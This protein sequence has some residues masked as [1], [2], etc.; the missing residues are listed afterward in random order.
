MLFDFKAYIE[1][2]RENPEKK[3]VVEKYEKIIWTIDWDTKDQIWYKEYVNKFKTIKYLVPEELKE[4][5]DWDLLMQLVASSLSSD[6]FLSQEEWKEI[7]EFTI[8]VQSGDQVVVKKV[9]ELWGFQ[10]S[11]LYEIYIEEQMN[12]QILMM[13]DEKEKNAIESQREAKEHRWTIVLENLEKEKL[14]KIEK[15]EKEEKLSDLMGQL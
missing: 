8:S 14:L 1:E 10:I 2:L 6:W 9:S 13:E 12:L 7:V 4:D 15:V 11:R 3:E 5:F